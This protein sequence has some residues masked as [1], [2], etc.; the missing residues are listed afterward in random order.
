MSPALTVRDCRGWQGRFARCAG[1]TAM[2]VKKVNRYY[3]EFCKKS[4]CSVFHIRR[5]EERCT[6]NPNRKCGMCATMAEEQ[7]NMEDLLA[8]LP[9][10]AQSWIEDE[11]G[12]SYRPPPSLNEAIDKLRGVAN[13][14]PACIL[15][16]LRQKGIPV[17]ATEFNFTKECK[18]FWSDINAQNQQEHPW[19]LGW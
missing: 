5:H 1:R 8:I 3:C 16:A 14:C 12:K 19:E 6:M 9:D 17:P 10:P 13:N 11:F 2:K 7:P 18:S 4:G 15:A